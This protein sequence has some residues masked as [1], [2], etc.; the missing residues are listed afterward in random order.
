MFWRPN[1]EEIEEW[2]ERKQRYF[3]IEHN[4][5]PRFNNEQWLERYVVTDLHEI[6]IGEFLIILNEWLERLV[7]KDGRY[8]DEAPRNWIPE[9][10]RKINTVSNKVSCMVYLLL[11]SIL[12]GY[13]IEFASDCTYSYSFT[14]REFF[15]GPCG[16]YFCALSTWIKMLL[17]NKNVMKMESYS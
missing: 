6:F 4:R 10:I 2:I 9:L 16:I 15:K 13:I 12:G 17:C 7:E 8:R 1:R 11:N 3:S 5:N 14:K